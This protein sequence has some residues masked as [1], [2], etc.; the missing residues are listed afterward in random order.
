MA[1]FELAVDLKSAGW[2]EDKIRAEL[3]KTILAHGDFPS[4]SAVE[5]AIEFANQSVQ[6]TGK[7][8]RA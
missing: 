2:S 8:P 6:A 4:Y 3:R 5:E 1:I 7:E